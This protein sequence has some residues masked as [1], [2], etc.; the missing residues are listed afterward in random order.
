MAVSRSFSLSKQLPIGLHLDGDTVSLA[1]V[2]V[3][4]DRVAIQAMASGELPEDPSDI[5]GA[6]AALRR[7]V[8]DHHFSTRAVVSCLAPRDLIVQNVRL[9]QVPEAEL[10]PLL[11]WEAQERLPYPVDEAELR[12]LNSGIVR[13]E[14]VTKQEVIL[15]A[16]RRD[17]IDRHLS[18]LEGAGLTPTAID[19]AGCGLLRCATTA[20]RTGEA[21]GDGASRRAYLNLGAAAA[22]T[23]VA[24]GGRI[25]FLKHLTCGGRQLDQTLARTLGL[26]VKE[27]AAMRHSVFRA[28][29][30]DAGDDLHRTV[31]DAIR[32]PLESLA[33]EVELCLRHVKVTFRGRPAETLTVTGPEAAPWIVEFLSDRLRIPATGFDPFAKF[34]SGD[35]APAFPGRFT[36]AVGLSLRGLSARSLES[37]AIPA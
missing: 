25:M 9:P 30:L 37:L 4:S 17:A 15:L 18:I 33:T 20:R 10:P 16:A 21:A 26:P 2:A 7:L 22:T 28:P 29:A 24:N 1:Q 34:G 12:H 6:V 5:A 8:A 3:Q 19:L 11:R 13:D 32:T 14:G 27:A 23:L 31:I 36:V 35:A